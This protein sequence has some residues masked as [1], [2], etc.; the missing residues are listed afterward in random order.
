M[1][2][3]WKGVLGADLAGDA[4][5]FPQTGGLAAQSAKVEE[6]GAAHLVAANLLDLVDDLGVEGKD[7]LDALAKAQLADG[8]RALRTAVDGDDQAFEGLQAF[9]IAFLDPAL[10]ANLVAGDEFGEIG[11]LELVGQALHYGMNGH[12]VFLRLDSEFSVYQ[13]TGFCA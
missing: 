6:L 2:R 13:R 7:A 5:H 4:V 11:A 12:G 9:L 3:G 10:D 8:K 1:E